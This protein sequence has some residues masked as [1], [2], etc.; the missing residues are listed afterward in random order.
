MNLLAIV[1]SPRKGKATDTLIDRAIEG[2]RSKDPDCTVTKI[3]LADHDIK[4]CTNC[5]A[6]R[7]NKT[8]E[9]YARCTIRDDMGDPRLPAKALGKAGALA[10]ARHPRRARL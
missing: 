7:D 1:G 6:C 9:S 4:H 3:H 2:V 10:M 5:L 8:T